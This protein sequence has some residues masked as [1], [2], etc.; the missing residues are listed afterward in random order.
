ML[1]SLFKY[2][3]LNLRF[4]VMIAM[5]LCQYDRNGGKLCDKTMIK[6]TTYA[7][8]LFMGARIHMESYIYNTYMLYTMLIKFLQCCSGIFVCFLNY[9]IGPAEHMALHAHNL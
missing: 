9:L 4:H 8:C 5:L 1:I 3:I 6:G 7:Y 2:H